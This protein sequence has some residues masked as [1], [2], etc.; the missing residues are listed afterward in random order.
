MLVVA[1]G[2]AVPSTSPQKAR[3]LIRE[4]AERALRRRAEI[5]PYRVEDPYELT[6]RYQAVEHAARDARLPGWERIDPFTVR[7]RSADFME[8]VM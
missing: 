5:R 1:S 4:G 3:R 8:I 6:I 2:V 7:K